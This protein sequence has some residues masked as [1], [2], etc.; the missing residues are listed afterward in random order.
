MALA[1]ITLAC[2]FLIAS[3]T[4]AQEPRPVVQELGLDNPEIKVVWPVEDGFYT[5]FFLVET[6]NISYRPELA[7]NPVEQFA[8]GIDGNGDPLLQNDGHVHGWVFEVDRFGQLARE[9]SG[10]PTPASYVRFYG[11]G[12]AEYFEGEGRSFYLKPDDLPRGRYRAYFQLQQ[13]DH[14][15]MRQATAPAFPGITSVD[16]F[17]W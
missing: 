13:N 16:F 4:Q 3:A 5:G 15:A 7:T 1:A 12:G 8:V 2:I 17:V 6:R 9:D 14:T 10:R 11:A